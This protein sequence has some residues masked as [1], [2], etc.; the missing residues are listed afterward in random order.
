MTTAGQIFNE[1]IFTINESGSGSTEFLVDVENDG[2]L[3]FIQR[4]AGT[5]T[6]TGTISTDGRESTPEKIL[7]TI[8][9]SDGD[10]ADFAV[11]TLRRM[12]ISLAWDD[13]CDVIVIVQNKSGG[14]ISEWRSGSSVPTT[15]GS[16]TTQKLTITTAPTQVTNLS[17]RRSIGIR[18]FNAIDATNF[19]FVGETAAILNDGWPLESRLGI[20]IDVDE[21]ASFYLSADVDTVDARII[22]I[23]NSN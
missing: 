18:N 11:L 23:K 14:A 13:A 3:I 4:T 5:A 15:N 2:C 7:E 22:Q 6:V 16:F 10:V 19:L 20:S 21:G 9:I 17:G 8:S 12:K 1:R